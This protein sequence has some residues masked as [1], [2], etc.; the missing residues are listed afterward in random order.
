MG[1]PASAE[2]T[3]SPA[4]GGKYVIPTNEVRRN[5]C[6]GRSTDSSLSVGMTFSRFNR[7]SQNTLGL[8]SFFLVG[9]LPAFV[10][11][12]CREFSQARTGEDNVIGWAFA[13]ADV[14]GVPLGD[15]EVLRIQ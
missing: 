7:E 15:D 9:F 11:L 6:F 5:L 10:D 4:F 2:N 3:G 12:P 8:S 13:V 1:I 14:I